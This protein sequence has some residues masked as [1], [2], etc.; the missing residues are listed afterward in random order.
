V[1][2]DSHFYSALPTECDQVRAKY[3]FFVYESGNAFYVYL[4][5]TSIGVCPQGTIPVYRV[6]NKRVDTNHRYTTGR[7]VR[8]AMIALGWIAEGYGVDAVAMCALSQ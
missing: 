6:W 4:P 8:D 2:G 5:D 7:S 3:P 1:Y